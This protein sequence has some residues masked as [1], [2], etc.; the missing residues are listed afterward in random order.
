MLAFRPSDEKKPLD[1]LP[2]EVGEAI[3]CAE[4]EEDRE[5]VMVDVREAAEGVD[6]A[7]EGYGRGGGPRGGLKSSLLRYERSVA[8][9]VS[10]RLGKVIS[11][12]IDDREMCRGRKLFEAVDG[13][14]G[15]EGTSVARFERE[16]FPLYCVSTKNSPSP[17]S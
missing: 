11:D 5:G 16:L 1:D 15:P 3:V 9:V 13:P 17:Q 10:A 2:L 4:D 12:A 6:W 7:K 8:V 14:R